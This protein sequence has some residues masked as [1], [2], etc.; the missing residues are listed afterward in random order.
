EL[1]EPSK[2]FLHKLN[3]PV[4]VYLILPEKYT[5]PIQTRFGS[6]PYERLYAD[7]RVLLEQ[8]ADQSTFFHPVY[9][10][11]SL[12]TAR[13][14]AVRDR[15]KVKIDNPNAELVGM[16]VAVG[17]NEEAS[18]FIPADDLVEAVPVGRS[19][20]G[21]VFQAENRLLTEVA[22]LADSRENE[23]IYFTQ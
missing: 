8:C 6:V 2:E 1:S 23:V 10:S 19:A 3:K 11:P 13:I 21:I 5:K 14:A 4:H 12:D 22:F 18:S 20:V 17:E 16:I 15:L 9:L 7:C